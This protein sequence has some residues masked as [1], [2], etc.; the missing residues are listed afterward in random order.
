MSDFS[1]FKG[2]IHCHT[3]MSD[4][5]ADPRV[6]VDWYQSHGYDFLVLSDHNHLT[7]F[8]YQAKGNHDLIL[9]PGEEVTSSVG[10]DSI[11]VHINGIGINRLVEPADCE[12]VLES[13]QINID[14]IQDAGG[15]VSINHPNFKWALTPEIIISSTGANMLEVFNGHPKTNTFGTGNKLSAEQIWDEV[16]TSGQKIFAAATDDTHNYHDFTPNHSNPGRGWLNVRARNLTSDGIINSL[17]SGDFYS[18]TGV[19]LNRIDV[20]QS[21]I[22]IE[23]EKVPFVEY[24]TVFVGAGGKV[25]DKCFGSN[26]KYTFQGEKNYV[27]ATI[28]DSNGFKA[29]IQPVH[30]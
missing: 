12:T 21:G 18:S 5:D 13:L 24:Q 6:A 3:T 23:I 11:P 4:G 17:R 28:S 7:L 26:P 30:I 19:V 9:I 29:W 1:W 27:R 10:V 20:H 14:R 16:L 25:L 15:L 2:N 22:G 8:D